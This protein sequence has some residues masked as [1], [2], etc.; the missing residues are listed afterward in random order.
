VEVRNAQAE[1]NPVPKKIII[2]DTEPVKKKPVKKKTSSK[3]S[4][5][6]KSDAAKTA[7]PK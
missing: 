2:D 7:P 4:K 1:A 3:T 6:T 5:A